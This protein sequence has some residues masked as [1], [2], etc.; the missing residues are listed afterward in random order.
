MSNVSISTLSI[1]RIV[2]SILLVIMIPVSAML[3]DRF[4]SLY[5]LSLAVSFNIWTSILIMYDWSLFGIH[6]NRVK[7]NLGNS[8]IFAVIGMILIAIWLWIGLH[9]LNSNV[10]IAKAVI[11]RRYGYARPA[12]LA[13]LSSADLV[14]LQGSTIPDLNISTHSPVLALKPMLFFCVSC[15]STMSFPECPAFSAIWYRG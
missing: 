11:L 14:T 1:K 5:T 7:R 8:L 6:Y 15:L 10:L 3:L 9:F 12:M 4:A 2:I 13:A